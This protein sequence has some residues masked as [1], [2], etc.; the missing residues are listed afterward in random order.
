MHGFMPMLTPTATITD[1]GS[2]VVVNIP[3]DVKAQ[4]VMGPNDVV[5]M[6]VD[7]LETGTALMGTTFDSRALIK[8]H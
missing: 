4:R 5:F 8:V 7:Y 1:I 6:T 2:A 3:V